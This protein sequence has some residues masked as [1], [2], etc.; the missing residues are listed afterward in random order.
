MIVEEL[1]RTVDGDP[2]VYNDTC[3][4]LPAL[5]VL[6]GSTCKKGAYY[7]PTLLPL[8]DGETLSGTLIDVTT[9]KSINCLLP[10]VSAG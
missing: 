6:A 1:S 4:P 5:R 9:Q 3:L 7:L 10:A 2:L 8:R